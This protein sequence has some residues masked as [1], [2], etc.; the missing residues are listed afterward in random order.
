[1]K[2]TIVGTGYVGL[3]SGVCL[4]EFGHR[5]ICVDTSADK[6]DSLRA[7]EVP[8]DEPGLQ[9]P[10]GRNIAAGRLTFETDITRAAREAEVI[11]VAVDTP[12]REEDGQADL[13]QVMGAVDG[14]AMAL[15]GH[16]VIVTKST[17]PVG[18]GRAIAARIRALRPDLDFDVASNP[19]FLREG[20]AIGDFLH[21]DRVVVGTT[22]ARG[23]AVMAQMYA[24]LAQRD[25]PILHT[26]LESSE[27]IKYASNGFLAT[28]ISFVNELAGLCE[29]I[30]ADVREVSLGM[31]LDTRIGAAFLQAGPGYGGSCFPKD[32]RALARMGQENGLA[33]HVTEAVMHVNDL[34][35]TRMIQKIVRACGGSMASM[36]VAVL[37]VTFKAET[38][39]MR[40][41]PSLTILPALI[42][43]GAL[44]RVVDPQFHR[45][46]AALLPGVTWCG[47]AYEAAQ[48]ADV[49]VV[50]TEWDDFGDLD[51]A[52]MARAMRQPRLVDLRNLFTPA[53][54]AQAGFVLY[55][56]IGSR[57]DRAEG[58]RPPTGPA[59]RLA[60]KLPDQGAPLRASNGPL[61][62]PAG[63]LHPATAT[64][65]G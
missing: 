55:D 41:A 17:V 57:A 16:A 15:T 23:Q 44:V 61:R 26:G 29:R 39:D 10:M 62:Q 52:R 56:A 11:I 46:G 9:A 20:S 54:A 32:T 7:G 24:P 30:G 19:E 6:I 40:E 8:I 33:L 4:A 22:W 2:I 60:G 64:A 36:T 53:A 3:V 65:G 43:G 21:P 38:D 35:K 27:L 13:T 5:V 49:L 12:M 1:M 31:G 14:I 58:L 51:L 45:Q 37:G 48:G 59:L 18:T 42:G 63:A 50:M 47:S 34:V 25:I 28:K